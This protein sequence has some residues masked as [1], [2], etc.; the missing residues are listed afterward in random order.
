MTRARKKGILI[1]VN[2]TQIAD[3]PAGLGPVTY[4]QLAANGDV[5]TG[6]TQVAQGDHDHEIGDMTLIFENALV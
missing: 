2:W 5:G 4:E 3:K 6:A 1:N